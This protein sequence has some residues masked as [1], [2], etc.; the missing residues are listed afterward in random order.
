MRKLMLPIIALALTAQCQFAA[1][2]A[3]GQSPSCDAMLE[4]FQKITGEE[5]NINQT[6]SLRRAFDRYKSEMADINATNA[7]YMMGVTHTNTSNKLW[8]SIKSSGFGLKADEAAVVKR[9]Q[10]DTGAKLTPSQI[11]DIGTTFRKWK[12]SINDAI[13]RFAN[14]ASPLSGCSVDQSKDIVIKAMLLAK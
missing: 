6:V 9:I 5:M 13:D 2:L 1:C 8:D 3:Q 14:E 10:T 4:N 11:Q 7:N 12:T